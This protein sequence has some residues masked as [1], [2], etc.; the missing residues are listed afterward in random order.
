MPPVKYFWAI[1][2]YTV[3]PSSYLV[4]N[5]IDRYTLGSPSP[6][7]KKGSDGSLTL[8]FSVDSPGKDKESNWLPVSKEPFWLPFRMYGPGDAILNGTYK[9]PPY[10]KAD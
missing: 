1:T 9:I 10:E 7:L 6:G 3:P 2:C 8:Y 5:P 4:A